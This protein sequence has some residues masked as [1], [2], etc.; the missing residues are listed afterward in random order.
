MLDDLLDAL[1]NEDDNRELGGIYLPDFV[2]EGYEDFNI[3]RGN[4]HDV[5]ALPDL[6]LR[7][8]SHR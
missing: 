1:F 8:R 7:G 5:E 2:D 3:K 4:Y 6:V